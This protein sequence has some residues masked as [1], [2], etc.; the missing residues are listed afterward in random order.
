MSKS[1]C[2]NSRKMFLA[3]SSMMLPIFCEGRVSK[4]EICSVLWNVF[5]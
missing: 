2:F 1:L 5:H 4:F 3:L